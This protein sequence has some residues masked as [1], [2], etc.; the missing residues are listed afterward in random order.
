[1]EICF[2]LQT[3]DTYVVFILRWWGQTDC[4]DYSKPT[5]DTTTELQLENV[6]GIFFIL[7]GGV[8][9]SLIAGV[10]TRC[11]S[12]RLEKKKAKA[13]AAASETLYTFPETTLS[14]S[15][16]DMT[17]LSPLLCRML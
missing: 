5:A 14:E 4:P 10:I 1:M 7:L 11:L 15:K 13:A 16:Y 6:A 8:G 9:V 2:S 12:Y 3:D 17:N